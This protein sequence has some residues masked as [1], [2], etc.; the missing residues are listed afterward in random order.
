MIKCNYA[1]VDQ[2]RRSFIKHSLITSG[3]AT[4]GTWGSV[5]AMA[6]VLTLPTD[7]PI[8]NNPL[9]FNGE[10]KDV[11]T[12][13]YH[14]GNGYRMYNPRLMRFHA[15]DSLSPF[16]QG[17]I[18]SYAYC[19][20][21][22]VNRRDPSGHFAILSFLIGAI[23]GA[24]VGAGISAVAEGV[25]AATTGDSFDWKQIGVG[26]A[27]GLIGGGFGAAAVGVKTSVQ[28]GL[29]IAETVVSNSVEFGLNVA[30]GMPIK[31]AGINSGIGT[32]I[33]LATFGVGNGIGRK[34]GNVRTITENALGNTDRL[35]KELVGYHGTSSKFTNSLMKGVNVDKY[36]GT[37]AG[38]K[39]GEG[40]Y[41]AFD[42]HTARGYAELA[43]NRHKGRLN[44]LTRRQPVVMGA[45]ID[46]N[47]LTSE[48][49]SNIDISL[50]NRGR[51]GGDSTYQALFLAE[52]PSKLHLYPIN[53][54]FGDVDKSLLG[55]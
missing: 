5:N 1:V 38:L 39:H 54:N 46:S 29:A 27:L 42:Y 55:F 48:L 30:T 23:V 28:V 26:A 51:R 18:N 9:G 21:N 52:A 31:T 41:T 16:G 8:I 45:Y 3:V 34:V 44:F 12:G 24:V 10:R 17:G 13:C 6:G 4:I 32:F 19:L 11:V 53:Q 22:P 35:N 15:S 2:S 40:F 14:L 25:R 20:G 43:N 7:N 36:G 47:D 49:F 50:L 37:S 33:G